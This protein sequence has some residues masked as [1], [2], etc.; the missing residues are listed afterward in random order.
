[1]TVR[2]AG[3]NGLVVVGV[4]LFALTPALS[5]QGRGGIWLVLSC[6]HP[7]PTLWIPVYAGMTVGFAKVIPMVAPQSIPAGMSNAGVMT[8]HY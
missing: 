5:H 6:W 7:H 8:S 2:D 4:G 3:N 1:M